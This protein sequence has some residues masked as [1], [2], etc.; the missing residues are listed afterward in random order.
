[1]SGIVGFPI[2]IYWGASGVT[3]VGE[4]VS[5]QIMLSPEAEDVRSVFDEWYVCT[6]P[7]WFS[8]PLELQSR[9]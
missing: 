2:Q 8:N 9:F 1:V 4:L 3:G 6:K 5:W 7:Q